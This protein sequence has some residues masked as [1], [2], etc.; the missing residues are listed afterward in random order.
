MVG[1]ARPINGG[2][3]LTPGEREA[4]RNAGIRAGRL[5]R[6]LLAWNRRT[7]QEPVHSPQ[8]PGEQPLVGC[9]DDDHAARFGRREPTIVEVIAVER[10]EGAVQ[11]PGE[12]E[13]LEIAGPAQLGIFHHEEHVPAEPPPHEA[14]ETRGHVGIGIDAGRGRTPLDDGAQLG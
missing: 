10:D 4:T 2:V 7:Q 14:H 8:H 3:N 6:A 11:P 9:R 1:G 12:P 13:V 5:G